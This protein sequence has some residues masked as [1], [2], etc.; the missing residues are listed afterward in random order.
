M[1][2]ARGVLL[3]ALVAVPR[4]GAQE[5]EVGVQ[6]GRFTDE[7]GNAHQG[8]TLAPSVLWSDEHSALRLSGQGTWLRGGKYGGAGVGVATTPLRRG[9]LRATVSGEG[10][11]AASDAGYRA[12]RGAVHPRLQLVPGAWGVEAGPVW[13]TG[14]DRAGAPPAGGL[15]SAA[16]RGASEPLRWRG[17]HGLAVGGW[18]GQGPATLRGSASTLASGDASWREWTAGVGLELGSAVVGL[19]LGRRS[20]GLEEGWGAGSL[21]VPL[22]GGA[23]LGVEVGSYPSDPLM[24]RA[25]G[26]YASAGVSVRTGRSGGAPALVRPAADG[27]VRIAIR[28][29]P[30]ARVELLGDWTDWQPRPVPEASPGEYAVRVALPAGT[31]RF[32]FRVDGELRVPD[33]FQAEQD[34][35]GGR[36]GVVRVR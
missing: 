9:V 26:S 24:G 14:G 20:G 34:E 29:R 7:R 28:A 27:R 33:G 8:L 36:R 21:R 17:Q 10:S 12:V 35:F 2:I 3:A 18:A 30:G 22:G 5:V 19:S 15:L 13:A 23:A 6:G 1:R 25:R 4:L 16:R 32:L 31:H 11:A